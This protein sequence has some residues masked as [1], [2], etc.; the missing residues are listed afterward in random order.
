[1]KLFKTGRRGL[2]LVAALF[3]LCSAVFFTT[4]A[5]ADDLSFSYTSED[6]ASTATVVFHTDTQTV[7]VEAL[8]SSIYQVSFETTFSNNNGMLALREVNDCTAK[9]AQELIDAGM[10]AFLPVEMTAPVFYEITE[11]DGGAAVK[12]LFG[13]PEKPEEAAVVADIRIDAD[14]LATIMA[15]ASEL[16]ELLATT[17]ATEADGEDGTQTKNELHFFSDGSYTANGVLGGLYAWEGKGDWRFDRNAGLVLS[18]VKDVELNVLDEVADFANQLGL[19]KQYLATDVRFFAEKTDDALTLEPIF[20]IHI[21]G[22]RLTYALS[23]SLHP[24]RMDEKEIQSIWDKRNEPAYPAVGHFTIG[25]EDAQKLGFSLNDIEIVEATALTLDRNAASMLQGNHLRLTPIFTPENATPK[26]VLFHSSNRSRATV[27]AFGLV[28]AKEPGY[29]RITAMTEDGTLQAEC[30]IMV[31]ER[32]EPQIDD[33]YVDLTG[34]IVSQTQG[35]NS[36]SFDADGNVAINGAATVSSLPF[37]FGAMTNYGFVGDQLVINGT[38]GTATDTSGF[39]ALLTGS[40]SFP[41][42]ISASVTMLE[43]GGASISVVAHQDDNLI[44]IGSY[45]LSKE[46]VDLLKQAAG[47]SV[48]VTGVTLDAN[49]LEIVMGQTAMLTA[50]IAPENA[51]VKNVVWTSADETIATVDEFGTVTA[52]AEGETVITVTTEDG[53]FE[54]TCTVSVISV[55]VTGITLDQTELT[56]EPLAADWSNGAMAAAM[57]TAT[58]LPENAGNKTVLWSSSDE[59]VAT[60]TDGLVVGIAEGVAVITAKTEDGGFEA[61]CTVTVKAPE[62]DPDAPAVSGITLDQTEL[63]LEPLAADWSNYATATAALTATVLPENAGNKT[64]LWSSSDESVATVTNGTVI[65]V[66]EGVAVITAKTE[67]GGFEATCTVTVKTPEVDPDAPAV[68]GITLDQTELT[69]EPLAADW[70]NY[71]TATAALTA[72]VLPENAGNRA[73]LWSSSDESVATVTNGTVIGVAE[74]VAVITAKTED[75][76]FE[77][78]CTVTVKAA[79]S[80]VNEPITG[81]LT[82]NGLTFSYSDFP[83]AQQGALTVS[84]T[85]ENG[86]VTFSTG[87][88]NFFSEA[89]KAFYQMLG[90]DE[91]TATAAAT[92][93]N[94][95]VTLTFANGTVNAHISGMLTDTPIEYDAVAGS[96]ALSAFDGSDVTL[97][98]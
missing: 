57:L 55:P 98:G 12:M 75:G 42:P 49:E 65:G 61:T 78:T 29:V 18:P 60:V 20:A 22:A 21:A 94:A 45:T 70:S 10:G 88:A 43:D 85:V 5:A 64:V 96:V 4:V 73:V 77:A 74:G 28:T 39:F 31:N 82:V 32:Q 40:S 9:M 33:P 19:R 34:V 91:A 83:F 59:S 35:E 23:E 81:K 72:T 25:E 13:D 89:G 51:T 52:I 27:D 76:G 79:G 95:T 11:Q 17:Y 71:A 7:S 44:P 41:I 3:M 54:A 86:T 47:E 36:I 6:G 90:L 2:A 63:T 53:G 62:V 67:D 97:G 50:T 37:K 15:S 58:V 1:M 16:R 48:A 46:E 93:Y 56:L 84:Y 8:A 30:E 87:T 69:L 38:T 26:K 24:S 68:F 80:E 92:V 14:S 66:A